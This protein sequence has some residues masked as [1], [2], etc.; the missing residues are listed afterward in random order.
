MKNLNIFLRDKNPLN[1]LF[2]KQWNMLTTGP[3]VNAD[4]LTVHYVLPVLGL[5]FFFAHSVPPSGP[6][7]DLLSVCF[8]SLISVRFVRLCRSAGVREHITQVAT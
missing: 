2:K 7:E 1:P 8:R 4:F 6:W 5:F 3:K